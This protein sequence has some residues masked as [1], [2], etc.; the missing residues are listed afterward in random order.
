[1]FHADESAFLKAILANPDDDTPR[2][3]YAD[4][5]DERNH[6]DDAARAAF[7][8]LQCR[9][10]SPTLRPKERRQLNRE[11]KAILANYEKQ[12][13]QPLRGITSIQRWSFRRGFLD[14]IV[15]SATS[16]V[17]NAAKIFDAAPTI[18]S[19][20]FR[21]ASNEVHQ[22]AKCEYLSRLATID[23]HKM[24]ICGFC[25]IHN[26][27]RALFHCRYLQSLQSLNIANNRMNATGAKHLAE[28]TSFPNLTFLDVSGNPLGAAGIQTLSQSQHLRQLMTLDLS[29]T[30]PDS[31]GLNTLGR[32]P[33]FPNLRTL[34]LRKNAL[35]AEKLT[36]FV[37][38]PLLAQL[39]TLDLT[40]NPLGDD[41][42]E[43]LAKAPESVQL[44]TLRL[45]NCGLNESGKKRLK[46]RF[47][48]VVK[49]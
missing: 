38:T 30:H 22:L 31:R 14:G 48:A 16:F 17:L 7:I 12:W 21:E 18:R 9:L 20:Y 37:T 34:A 28:S 24:C 42:A 8:R 19:A 43:V 13:T 26:D 2:F 41:G 36:R 47:G 1:M 3:V 6:G 15:M 45:R 44:Q 11:A 33:S 35:T 49:F 10:E 32:S 40:S 5:L 27:L 4:W 46:Q 25:P 39:H 29:E 23:L